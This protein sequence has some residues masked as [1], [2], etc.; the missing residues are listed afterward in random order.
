MLFF[1]VDIIN[2][3]ATFVGVSDTASQL[4]SNAFH[5]NVDEDCMAVLPGVLSRKKQI[6]PALER[7]SM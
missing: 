1:V 4:V 6:V 7:A 2:E 3:E 5:T